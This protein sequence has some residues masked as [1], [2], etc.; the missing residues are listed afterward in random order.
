MTASIILPFIAT[1]LS[2]AF[3]CY[4][5]FRIK[6]TKSGTEKM[7]EVSLAIKQGAKTFLKREFKTMAIVFVLAAIVLWVL[8]KSFIPPLLFLLGALISS[9]AGF[10]GMMNATSA[11]VRTANEA[12]KSFPRSFQT[13]MQG[14]EVMGFLV[15]GLGL[16]GVLIF[17][18]IFKDPNLLI[19]YAFGASFV[20]L[21]MRVGGGIFTKSADIGADLVGKT[22]LN[23]PEDDPRNPAVIADNVGDNVGDTAGMGAD[24]FESYVSSIIAAMVIGI[25]VVGEKGVILPLL[26]ASL[27]ILS[28]LFGGIFIRVSKKSEKE[29]FIQQTEKVRKAMEKGIIIA[30]ITMIFLSFLVIWFLFD[31]LKLFWVVLLGLIAGFIIGKTTEYY[32]SEKR[33]PTQEIARATQT[34]TPNVILEGLIVGMKSTVLP[35][36]AV[37]ITIVLAY[38]L[39]GL[40]G[41]ALASVGMLGVLG[42]NLSTDC[43]GPIADNA[44]GIAEMAELDSEVRQ[45]VEAL[46]A[47]GN[48][49]AATGKGFAIGAAALAA[50]SWLA[51]YSQQSGLESIDLLNPKVLAGIFV[52]AVLPFLFSAMA[53]KGVNQGAL[54]IVK[55]VR[56]QFKEKK[57]LL[58]GK[59]KA[60]YKRCIDIAT[61]GALREM[62]YPAVMVVIAPIIIGVTLGKAAVA[63]MLVGALS[64][65]FLLAL[66]MAN[67]GAAWDNAKKYIEAGNLGGKGSPQ[68][69]SA[70]VGDTI[71]DP[72]K[73][74][75]GPSLNILIKLIS[76]VSLIALPLFL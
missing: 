53:M 76:V 41:I 14:G 47:V 73:D 28:S 55:E 3:V 64:S 75:A 35:V 62:V 18:L 15:V 46:D 43:Y 74:T 32:T 72:F 63:G 19:N 1:I 27:G 9:F 45:K 66:L 51:T 36:L 24:L 11:N 5:Y 44:A 4:L 56:R 39:G 50:L 52:G 10:V 23:I 61:K 12:R 70:V 21:F 8:N 30:N 38:Y 7:Q 33:K 65:G 67:S 22:E 31:T 42:I 13:A 2:L 6:R 34:G 16:L 58:E 49:T 57:G 29:E 40:Y 59:E 60:D 69:K 25:M 26:L 37:A 71:G 68:H 48:S 54:E 17:Y 20:A